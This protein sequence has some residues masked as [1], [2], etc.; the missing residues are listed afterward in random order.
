MEALCC[1]LIKLLFSIK[2]AE[3]SDEKLQ[4][5]QVAAIIRKQSLMVSLRY[6]G[7]FFKI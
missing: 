3:F 6:A 5:T 4:G 1:S 2:P 7:R